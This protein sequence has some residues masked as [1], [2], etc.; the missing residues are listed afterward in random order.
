MK[1]PS[2]SYTQSAGWVLL[3]IW[4]CAIY[5]KFY[6]AVPLQRWLF[7][8]AALRACLFF[9]TAFI[10]SGYLLLK[11]DL[12]TCISG[13]AQGLKRLGFI[14]LGILLL[15]IAVLYSRASLL[16]A[17]SV[18]AWFSLGRSTL[19]IARCPLRGLLEKY[20]LC[21]SL[22]MV[23]YADFVLLIGL[24]GLLYRTT[25]ILLIGC[26]VF[27]GY[28]FFG[29]EIIPDF[30][31]FRTY[32]RKGLSA[33]S[34]VEPLYL[35]V[36]L[37]IALYFLLFVL[38][39][40]TPPLSADDLFYHLTTAKRFAAAHRVSNLY[41]MDLSNL[42]LCSE[43]LY[44][45]GMVFG[46]TYIYGGLVNLVFVSLLLGAFLLLGQRIYNRTAGSIAFLFFFSI[47]YYTQHVF[48]ASADLKYLLF[49]LLALYAMLQWQSSRSQAWLNACGFLI[50]CAANFRYQ[51]LMLGFILLLLVGWRLY[52]QHEDWAT[53][54][55]HVFRFCLCIGLI[56]F[57][58]YL[59]NI[60]YTGNPIF[61]ACFR[62]YHGCFGDPIESE[63][64][65]EFLDANS[66]TIYGYIRLGTSLASYLRLPWNLTFHG[67]NF[68]GY[69]FTPVYFALAPMIIWIRQI[70]FFRTTL[71]FCFLYATG[72]FFQTEE[73]KFLMPAFAV[74][75]IIIAAAVAETGS[76]ERS[77]LRATVVLLALLPSLLT[78]QQRKI[79]T[80][81]RE[82]IPTALR[83]RSPESFLASNSPV[84]PLVEFINTKLPTE[85]RLFTTEE[86]RL[87]F[88]HRPIRLGIFNVRDV[89]Y[90][91]FSSFNQFLGW[92][93]TQ[94]ITHI[95]LPD[96]MNI[97]SPLIDA[98]QAS[99]QLL[100]NTVN[101]QTLDILWKQNGSLVARI[102]YDK[103]TLKD[104]V[105]IHQDMVK[106]ADE[107]FRCGSLELAKMQ[108]QEALAAGH[109]SA[110]ER[111]D[112]IAAMTLLQ[113]GDYFLAKAREFHTARFLKAALNEYESLSIRSTDF[114]QAEEGKR[115]VVNYGKQ[116]APQ[117]W[118]HI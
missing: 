11:L 81:C 93:Q 78:L 39:N 63:W 66:P 18:A 35:L 116:I 90:G 64:W 55:Q 80:F 28:W 105:P 92:L 112:E 9:G 65:R 17:V 111:L 110:R 51:G 94:G 97:R 82:R 44:A 59:K 79:Q 14:T 6:S 40:L 26:S 56:G 88:A 61:P 72:W 83:L 25:L 13:V 1:A 8:G 58:W 20:V 32:C 76:S 31:R 29:G 98:R 46:F 22:G 70:A 37:L 101:L 103:L 91:R 109:L 69:W 27:L 96:P 33:T 43:M 106:I 104:R 86:V 89:D 75:G 5:W 7:Y 21:I 118:G 49:A 36:G 115:A 45:Q 68:E 24:M 74:F 3:W 54:V 99:Y 42:P 16:L 62:W 2:R 19:Q 48:S 38:G 50:G 117:I 30:N 114:G 60:I 113:K 15:S 67:V 85:A 47:P 108:Y 107:L 95:I 12:G 41:D 77:T 102:N 84:Q 23:V 87:F 34:H 10:F 71:L 57:P 100:L 4:S 52:R 53:G 73:L